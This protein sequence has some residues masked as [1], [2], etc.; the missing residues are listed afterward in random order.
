MSVLLTRRRDDTDLGLY[1]SRD[2]IPILVVEEGLAAPAWVERLICGWNDHP[3][4]TGVEV[5]GNCRR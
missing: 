1:E 3:I 5:L 4:P 2:D